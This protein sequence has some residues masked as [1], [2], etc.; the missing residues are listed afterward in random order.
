M[1]LQ[2]AIENVLRQNNRPM[3]AKEI[4]LAI[5]QN[6]YYRGAT[7]ETIQVDLI[8]NRV[9]NH[10]STF[11]NING[12]IILVNNKT[13]KNIITSYEYL[14]NELKGI[15]IQA[16]IQFIIA[17]LF[18]YKRLVDINQRPGRRYPLE[19][20]RNLNG[21]INILLDGGK[22][23]IEGFKTIE[24]Y[25]ISPKGVFDECARLLAKLDERK[26]Q[27]LWSIIKQIQTDEIE[28][29]EFGAIYEYLITHAS[30]TNNKPTIHHTPYSLRQL[31]VQLLAVKDG[32]SV[33]DPVAGAGG[34]LIESSLDADDNLD[35]YGSE[36]NRR[37]A[38]LGKMNVSMHGFN[39][40]H[41]EAEDCFSQI[42]NDKQHD[43]IIADLPANGII[44]STEYFAIY[45]QH[46]LLPPKSGKSFGALVLFAL[47][48][49]KP[50]GR[51]VLTLSDG[52]LKKKGKEQEIREL[53]IEKDVIETIV[54]LPYGSLRPYTDA[55]AS[56][57]VLNKNKPTHLKN[58][59]YFIT[60]KISDQTPKSVIL[61]TDEILR[62]YATKK[63]HEKNAH[64]VHMEDLKPNADLLAESYDTQFL[65]ANKMLKEGKAK[66]LSDLV[67]I[68][69][70][71]SPEKSSI[72]KDGA[73]PLIKVEKLSKDILDL[74]LN[75]Q[76]CDGV[77]DVGRYD[78]NLISD[79]CILVARIGDSL[80]ATV[81]RPSDTISKI[82][83]HNNVYAL[84]PNKHLDVSIEYL[85]YQLHSTFVQEQIKKR[86]LGAVM[87]YISILGLKEIVIP[88]MSIEAQVEFVESQKANLIAEERN[89]VEE[90]IKSLGYK[91]ETKQAEAD[92]IKTLTHQLR[93]KLTIL[94]SIAN[95]IDRIVKRE[96]IGNTH[97]G[98]NSEN[99]SDPELDGLLV[100]AENYTLSQLLTKLQD[101]TEHLSEIITSV[102]KVM[103]FNLLD[104]DLKEV[105]V[106]LFL[107]DYVKQKEMED[108]FDYEINIKGDTVVVLIHEPSFKDLLD[109]LLL[110]AENH[111]FKERKDSKQINFLIKHI[112]TRDIVSIEY[113][114]NGKPFNLTQKDFITAFEKGQ[115]SNGSGIGGNYISRI[116]DAH[117]GKLIIEEKNNKGFS[118]TIELPIL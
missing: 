5:N 25:Y 89:R 37:I 31:M 24:N 73:I 113:S 63:P 79:E 115:G 36:I 87:P 62:L 72:H 85:Y 21:S 77:N 114:N 50:N 69:L 99:Y 64:M 92:V 19:F 3:R 1:T 94:N 56:I 20:D 108:S 23:L 97:E 65:L 90:R 102:D 40:I 32:G 47:A 10:P 96:N 34:L 27:E 100:P 74:N 57:I 26:I 13:W 98:S 42:Y 59:I 110:N 39:N 105:D 2:E 117:K 8:Y 4:A 60:G 48:K 83:P 30:L 95:R 109:Q 46:K 75:I 86:K 6:R 118:L 82:L 12:H 49:L 17:V 35:A 16:D 84:I 28:D 53:L 51:A 66:F 15:F 11:Q 104:E 22:S 93:P 111:A 18:F 61:N 103:N 116:I 112:K 29:R 70:G 107:K 44:N 55:K 101:E 88:F 67:Q 7:N 80:K 9:R 43:Y 81:F 41:I 45:N 78:R 71:V 14:V 52:F 68:K 54:S 106:L 38:Q 58:Y 76:D 33:Y 91:E